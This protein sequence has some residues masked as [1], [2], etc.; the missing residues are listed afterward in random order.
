MRANSAADRLHC[1]ECRSIL[2]E[3]GRARD[4]DRRAGRHDHRRRRGVD[5]AVHLD[6]HTETPLAD[7]SGDMT[8]LGHNRFYELLTAEA[9]VHGHDQDVVAE[10]ER[11]GQRFRRSWPG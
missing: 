5:A 11:R 1:S 7:E 8:D 10:V 6:L 4:E 3:N 2:S 9:G